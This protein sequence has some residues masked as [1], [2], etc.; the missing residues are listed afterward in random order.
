MT[1]TATT[2]QLGAKLDILNSNQYYESKTKNRLDKALINNAFRVKH[3]AGDVLYA[4]DEFMEKNTDTLFKEIV[5]CLNS[6]AKPI[7]MEMFPENITNADQKR[8]DTL[9]TQ[10][11]VS[12]I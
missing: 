12:H 8:P 11:R 1:S 10:F 5:F 7:V 2:T 3:Y 9:G 6:S 4:I